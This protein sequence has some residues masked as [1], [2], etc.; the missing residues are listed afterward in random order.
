MY[1]DRCKL[2]FLEPKALGFLCLFSPGHF[3]AY[4]RLVDCKLYQNYGTRFSVDFLPV[5]EHVIFPF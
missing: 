3:A 4:N 1:F 2:A 5:P